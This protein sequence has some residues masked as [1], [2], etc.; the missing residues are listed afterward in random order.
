MI[1]QQ[2]ALVPS[3]FDHS[4]SPVTDEPAHTSRTLANVELTILMPCLNEART[5]GACVRDA[6]GFLQR[7]GIAGEVLVADN[8]STDGSREIAEAAGARVVAVLRRGYGA[9]LLGGIQAARGAYV[10]MGDADCSY[11]FSRLDGFVRKLRAGA[12]LVMGNR[13]AGGIEPGAMPLLHRY[14][15]NPVLSFM[16]RLFF[17]TSISDFHCGLRGFSRATIQRLGLVTHGMEFASEMVAK[18]A[19]A[20]LRIDE[21]PT[22]LRPDGRDRPPHLRTWRDGWRHLRFLLLFCPR[23]LFLYP[24]MLLLAAGLVGFALLRH[25]SIQFSSVGLGVHSL[26]YMA[27]AT[28]LGMQLIQ[29]AVLT[30]WMGVLSRM[31]PKPRWLRYVEPYVSLELGLL[32]GVALLVAGIL[33]S[34]A[35]VYDWGASGF[36]A[37]NPAEAMRAVIP[38]VTLMIV[39]TQAAAGALFAAALKACWPVSD[40]LR[41]HD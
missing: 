6:M 4:A 13:F 7:A 2:Q 26:L 18:A 3:C 12:D 21:E 10:V 16:G 29:L 36:G 23:W 5:V 24:G 31:V 8:G 20:G 33:W 25:G 28:V 37:L 39:G 19:L 35:I 11:D 32:A 34:V 38:A 30:K 27:A 9:A 40:D 41:R 14:L 17:R 15:G 22:T 1:Q